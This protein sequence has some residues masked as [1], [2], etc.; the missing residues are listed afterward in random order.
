MLFYSQ[1]WM[2]VDDAAAVSVAITE[3]N[4]SQPPSIFQD[5]TLLNFAVHEPII[6]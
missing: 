2:G 5:N 6:T 1:A 3:Y 4:I